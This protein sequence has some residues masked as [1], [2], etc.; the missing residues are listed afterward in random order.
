M[1]FDLNIDNYTRPELIE[2]FGLPPSYD[3]QSLEFKE[4]KL[5]ENIL[6]NM[7]INKDTQTKTLNFIIQ[8]KNILLNAAIPNPNPSP[9]SFGQ[10]INSKTIESIYHMNNE[11]VPTQIQ[12]KTEHMVQERGQK[13]YISSKPGE[14]FQGVINP[15]NRGTIIKNLNIIRNSKMFKYSKINFYKNSFL[16]K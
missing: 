1:N 8:A 15:L 4:M 12:N 11:L 7:Q 13:P 10:D 5:R 14:F 9:S 16:K 6:N 3:I 2:M